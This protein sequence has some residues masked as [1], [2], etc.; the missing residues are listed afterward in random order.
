MFVYCSAKTDGSTRGGGAKVRSPRYSTKGQYASSRRRSCGWR[1]ELAF[2]D[3]VALWE[4]D[5]LGT[6]R[7]AAQDSEDWVAAER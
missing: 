6:G 1:R 5:C 3:R 7:P 4:L 2:S